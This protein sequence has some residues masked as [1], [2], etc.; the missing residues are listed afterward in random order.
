MELSHSLEIDKA[1]GY[2][3]QKD[4]QQVSIFC[5]FSI[6]FIRNKDYNEK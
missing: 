1:I 6:Y 5:V 3:K 4:F 2:L